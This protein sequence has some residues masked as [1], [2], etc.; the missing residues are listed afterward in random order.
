MPADAGQAA[1]LAVRGIGRGLQ[2]SGVHLQ[3][4]QPRGRFVGDQGADQVAEIA[5]ED[6]L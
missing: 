1:R 6:L 5:G 3:G 4:R 2:S